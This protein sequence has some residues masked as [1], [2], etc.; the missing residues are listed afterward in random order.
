MF[1]WIIINYIIKK[2]I[3]QWIQVIYMYIFP[4]TEY[5]ILVLSKF[6]KYF[7]RKISMKITYVFHFLLFYVIW[8]Y[9]RSKNIFQTTNFLKL[10]INYFLILLNRLIIE[11]QFIIFYFYEIWWNYLTT[12]KIN[13]RN[14]VLVTSASLNY[15]RK[16]YSLD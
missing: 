15:W 8:I 9:F 1:G 16:Q 7:R 4:I 2:S 12:V 5:F 10:M 3:I 6:F 14:S 13:V 11:I